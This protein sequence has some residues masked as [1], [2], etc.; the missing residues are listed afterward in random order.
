MSL[1]L[2]TNVIFD[3]KCLFLKNGGRLSNF[4]TVFGFSNVKSIEITQ[5][6]Y[7]EKI[8]AEQ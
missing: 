4:V 7:R 2:N 6:F 8:D 3:F 1:A 5:L